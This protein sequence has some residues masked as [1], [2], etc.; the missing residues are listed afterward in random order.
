[1]VALTTCPILFA[2]FINNGFACCN[3]YNLLK[4]SPI[5]TSLTLLMALIVLATSITTSLELNSDDEYR[6]SH[7]ELR[8]LH[9]ATS[10][11]M[12]LSIDCMEC[13]TLAM[14]FLPLTEVLRV[15][16]SHE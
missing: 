11:Q 5:Q 3:F 7:V 6:A 12:D 13:T 9:I 15:S 16:V 1:M 14:L 2:S 10:V 4:V 8:Y